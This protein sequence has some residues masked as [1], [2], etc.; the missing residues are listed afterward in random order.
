[1]KM[2]SFVLV[3]ITIVVLSIQ[4]ANSFIRQSDIIKRD[5]HVYHLKNAKKDNDK[6]EQFKLQQEM[7][8]M[9]KDK[10]KMKE[11]FEKRED[12]RKE[13]SKKAKST[14]WTN[15]KGDPLSSWKKAKDE[16]KIKNLGYEEVPPSLFGTLVVPGN[17]IGRPEMDNGERFDLRLPYAERG[18]ED[19]DA[20]VMGK[21]MNIF[22]K[23]KADRKDKKKNDSIESK[24]SEKLNKNKK[25][26]FS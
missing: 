1:M 24:T 3:I 4:D 18:Y 23:K 26:W 14:I 6:E 7:L 19:P 12:E 2:I 20:D 10:K 25:G 13:V 16:G 5:I 17:P 8:R 21:F 9:R 15:E 11:Y 22:S